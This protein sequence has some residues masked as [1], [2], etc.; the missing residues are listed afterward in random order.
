MRRVN[1]LLRIL[2]LIWVV[3]YLFVSCAPL[4]N[5]ELILGSITLLGGIIFF[6][7]WVVGIAV[8]VFLIWA[9]NPRRPAR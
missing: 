9:T 4:L 3:G 6:V 7:P 5:G 8:L 1:T 2:L